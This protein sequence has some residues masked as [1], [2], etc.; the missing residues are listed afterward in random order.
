MDIILPSSLGALSRLAVSAHCSNLLDLHHMLVLSGLFFPLALLEPELSVVHQLAHRRGGLGRDL[1]QIQAL[2]VSD[3]Q[4]L[5]RG[6]DSKLL[7]LGADQADLFV[8]DG[9]I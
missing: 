2:L 1:D 8:I 3:P 7:T 6:H 9:F 4:R 5:R